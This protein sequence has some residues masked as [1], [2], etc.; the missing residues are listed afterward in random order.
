MKLRY[1]PFLL[2]LHSTICVLLLV[3][4][5]FAIPAWQASAQETIS[6]TILGR[7]IDIETRRPIQG[8]NVLVLGTAW[9]SSTN[10]RGEFSIRNIPPGHHTLQFTHVNY[11]T[12]THT[13]TF[14]TRDGRLLQV[15][16]YG[17]VIYIGPVEVVDTPPRFAGG[18]YIIGREEILKVN[19]RT[20]G[21]ALRQ[22]VPRIWVTEDGGNLYIQLQLRPFIRR[23]GRRDPNP[24]IILNGMK[25]GNSPI[26][27]AELVEPSQ[28]QRM[29]VLNPHESE[30]LYG[31]EARYG[32]II[33]DTIEQETR[34]VS[35]LTQGIALGGI[36]ASILLSV[37]FL[38][39]RAH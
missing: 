8:V 14:T 13:S 17:R 27:L 39:S 10:E 31:A 18:A 12:V 37:Y 1:I 20:F 28:I 7:V 3:V 24:L 5:C 16:M 15:E 9:G 26:G 6:I 33:I 22:L 34:Q 38:V 25:I 32:V 2:G 11:D 30:V 19:P 29:E 35:L 4:W 23:F 36:I 21:D